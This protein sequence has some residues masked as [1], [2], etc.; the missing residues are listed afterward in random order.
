[1][2]AV[3][4]MAE[5]RI[6]LADDHAIV[7]EGLKALINA[8]SGMTVVGE[9]ADGL[10]AC[11]RISVL[12]PDIV[13]M[14]VSMPGLSGSQA[15]ARLRQECP[16]VR[17]LALTVHE[18]KGYIRQLLAAGAVGYVLKRTAPEELIHAIR[19][20]ADGGVY[21]DPNVAGKVVGG[22]VRK[23]SDGDAPSVELSEREEAVARKT[24]AGHSNKEIASELDL[25]I[26]TVETYRARAMEKLGLQ[27]RAALVRYAVQQGWLQD[28]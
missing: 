27:G 23:L 24:A 28:G 20:V 26:K 17:V 1:M 25:S 9:A 13:V 12:R 21:L 11:E 6:F 14:D 22:F 7:R 10:H 19:A 18:D 4:P 16:S 2:K 8:Q 5:L 15:T 3:I